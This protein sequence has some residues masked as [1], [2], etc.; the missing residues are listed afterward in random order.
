MESNTGMNILAGM[1]LGSGV[2]V[3][4]FMSKE[5]PKMFW[6]LGGPMCNM[7]VLKMSVAL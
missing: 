3:D 7:G 1:A 6:S 5:K 4:V 2:L